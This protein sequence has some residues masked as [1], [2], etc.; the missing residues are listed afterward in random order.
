MLEMAQNKN[1]KQKLLNVKRHEFTTLNTTHIVPTKHVC[2]YHVPTM[3]LY[4]NTYLIT[5][6]I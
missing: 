3:C 2:T 4:S 1:T 5:L 6:H